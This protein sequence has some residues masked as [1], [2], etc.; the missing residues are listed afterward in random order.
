MNIKE[1][2]AVEIELNPKPTTPPRTPSRARAFPMNR[3]DSR[4]FTHGRKHQ[5]VRAVLER[6]FGNIES[7]EF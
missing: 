3:P 2:R 5:E 7:A 4:Y 1:I 6:I